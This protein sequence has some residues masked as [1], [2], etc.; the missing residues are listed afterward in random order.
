MVIP[1]GNGDEWWIVIGR[2]FAL[3]NAPLIHRLAAIHSLDLPDTF[4]GLVD[5]KVST[6]PVLATVQ[7]GCIRRPIRDTL[8]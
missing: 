2:V 4:S 5:P 8:N 3:V 7:A 6:E 1:F